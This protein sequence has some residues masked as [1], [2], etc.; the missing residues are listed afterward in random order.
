MPH[1]T[2]TPP[3][4]T[5][6]RPDPLPEG[7]TPAVA[8]STSDEAVAPTAQLLRRLSRHR[9]RLLRRRRFMWRLRG[10][11]FTVTGRR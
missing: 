9:L 2:S 5:E 3:S 7:A 8:Q 6:G 10:D 1:H 4:V 11:R